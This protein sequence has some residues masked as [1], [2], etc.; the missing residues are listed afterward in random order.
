MK[1]LA[2]EDF[3]IS[4]ILN[5]GVHGFSLMLWLFSGLTILFMLTLSN[6]SV[7]TVIFWI[8]LFCLSLPILKYLFYDKKKYIKESQ[9][10]FNVV[11]LLPLNPLWAKFLLYFTKW[12]PPDWNVPIY[13]V[14]LDIKKTSQSEIITLLQQDLEYIKKQPGIYIWQ[15]SFPIPSG[16]RKEIRKLTKQG[17]AFWQK[18]SFWVP[19][20]PGTQLEKNKNCRYGAVYLKGV[21][22][23]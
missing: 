11:V 20:F 15:T 2:L 8:I 3:N 18:G 7:Y 10:Y 22:S 6:V 23:N 17:L 5:M 12:T 14:H 19:R 1:Y 13:E 9:R 21:S 4:V 16:I